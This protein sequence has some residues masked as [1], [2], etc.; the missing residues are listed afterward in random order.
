LLR[1]V[2][3]DYGVGNLYSLKCALKK[4][5]FTPIIGFSK[6]LLKQADA[7]VLPGVGN[8]STAS[9]KLATIRESLLEL[10][11]GRTPFFGICLGMQLLFRK[12][13]EGIGEGLAFFEGENVRLPGYVKVPH[14]GWNT[15]QDTAPN[16][17][18]KDLE[19]ESYFYFAHSYYPIPADKNIVCAETTYGVRF[20]SVVAEQNIFGTQFHPEKSGLQGLQLLKNFHDLVKR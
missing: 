4:V 6:R 12:S 19:N 14:M 15:V 11:K 5:G 20:A 16:I 10:V 18:L 9:K 2:I 8:F 3:I 7:I 1:A 13:E 17:L